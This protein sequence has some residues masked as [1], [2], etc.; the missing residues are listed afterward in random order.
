VSELP[1]GWLAVTVKDVADLRSGFG[2]PISLQG[3]PAGELGFYKVGDISQNWQRR[4]VYLSK[5][6]HYISHDEAEDLRA[7]AFPA[8]SVVFAKIG[9]A[10]ALNRR[11]ILK[12]A[13]LLDNNVM[14][15]APHDWTTPEFLFH[16][17]CQVDLGAKTR[18]GNV[19][20]LRK[21]DVEEIPFPLPPLAE[22]K[23]IVA[24]IEELF[25]ELEAGEESLRVARRQLGVYRQSLLKQAFEG[26]LTAH[27]RTQNPAKLES[28]AQL[29]ARIREAKNSL[30]IRES[31]IPPEVLDRARVSLPSIPADWHWLRLENLAL[32]GTGMSVSQARLYDDPI[33]VPYLRVANVQRGR[34]D[35]AEMRTMLV[36]KSRLADL[37]LKPARHPV[38]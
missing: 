2:F 4:K 33:E 3:R 31:Q 7:V 23:R 32:I 16:F 1:S 20:S 38:Q 21:G 15:L 11:A 17:M 19:P 8:G 35:L 14:G 22:Q 24:K 13:S 9:A 6:E 18:G 25:S 5:A 30:G 34:L 26:K 29:L 27:W 10:V 37:R 12:E 36:E 28:P